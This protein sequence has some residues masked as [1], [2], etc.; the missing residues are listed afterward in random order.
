MAQK[1]EQGSDLGGGIL[2]DAVQADEGV[3]HQEAWAD[4]GDG[5]FEAVAIG[6]PIEAQGS[7][8]DDLEVEA[9]QAHASG[10]ADAVEASA[11]DVEGVLGGVEQHGSWVGHREAAQAPGAGGDGDREVESQE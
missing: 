3:E 2:I 7:S 8:G 1:G 4:G 11:D 9:A 5:V 10:A 6:G